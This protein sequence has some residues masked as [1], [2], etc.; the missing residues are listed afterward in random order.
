MAI[1]CK[2]LCTFKNIIL[3]VLC[4]VLIFNAFLIMEINAKLGID[5][6]E[7]KIVY[8]L[9]MRKQENEAEKKTLRLS[10]DLVKDAV[11]IVNISGV[12]EGYGKK[13]NV[14]YDAVQDSINIMK[15]YDPSQNSMENKDFERYINITG[16]ISCE[17]CCTVKALTYKD[18]NPTCD[19]EHAK[20]MRGLAAYLVENFGNEFS[21]ENILRELSRWKGKYFPR[22]MTEKIIKEIKSGAYSEDI[23][24][25]LKG[26]DLPEYKSKNE[27]PAGEQLENV[28]DMVGGC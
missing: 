9:I 12:P 14:S 27:L 3:V 22:Q 13:L 17:F 15:N 1:S 26:M 20:A 18:G 16:K 21:D 28:P 4:A 5:G 6:K 24:S 23:G 11:E 10:G 2:I 19:C 25:L 7:E 8:A